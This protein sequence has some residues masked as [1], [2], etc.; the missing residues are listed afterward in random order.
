MESR[1]GNRNNL[2]SRAHSTGLPVDFLRMVVEVFT[3][4]FDAGLKALSKIKPN[5]AFQAQGAI[6]SNEIILSVSLSHEGQLAATTVHVSCD[7]DPKASAPTAEDLLGTLVDAAGSVFGH[8]LD[9]KKPDRLEQLADESLSALEE[10]PFEWTL[11][12]LDN[13]RVHVKVDK[14]NLS[15]DQ[16][17]DEWLLKNDPDIAER[18]RQE[19]AETEKLFVTGPK[20]KPS[21]GDSGPFGGAGSNSIH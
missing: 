14:S 17:T 9:A 1:K 12:E 5:P 16:M 15:I 4:N 7:F 11:L 10:A 20:K 21:D 19:Q 18:E 13:R 6:Y 2:T 8:F 3:A